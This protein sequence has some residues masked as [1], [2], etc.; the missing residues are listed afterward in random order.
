MQEEFLKRLATSNLLAQEYSIRLLGNR[1][2]RDFRKIL[3]RFV[4]E[5][6]ITAKE[7]AMIEGITK[8]DLAILCDAEH[9]KEVFL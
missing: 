1:K 5:Q 8:D 4:G 9:L 2:Y 7:K 6:P 3:A